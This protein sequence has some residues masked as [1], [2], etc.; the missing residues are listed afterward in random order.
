M[1]FRSIE[2]GIREILEECKE[3]GQLTIH[4]EKATDNGA[5]GM[6]GELFKTMASGGGTDSTA[7]VMIGASGGSKGGT[8]SSSA[9]GCWICSNCGFGGNTGKFCVECGS[10]R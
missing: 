8:T 10:R 7:G 9:A 4:E 5:P 3:R 6:F 1:T 2:A